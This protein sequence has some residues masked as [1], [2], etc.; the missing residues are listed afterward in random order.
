[1]TVLLPLPYLLSQLSYNTTVAVIATVCARAQRHW[2]DLLLP[3]AAAGRGSASPP[4]LPSSRT[5]VMG[6]VALL[7]LPRAD[8]YRYG[9]SEWVG[10]VREQKAGTGVRVGA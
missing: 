10:S 1:M 3:F 7:R 9:S 8:Q 5:S 2:A 4:S 6:A